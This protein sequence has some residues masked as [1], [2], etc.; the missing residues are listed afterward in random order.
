MR[1]NN[2][3]I[4]VDLGG[5]KLA[6]GV[7]DAHGR[8]L[9]KH[10]TFDHKDLSEEGVLD[11]MVRNICEALKIAGLSLSDATGAGILFPGHIR[12]PEGITL[13]TS[14]LPGF[15]NFPL[16]KKMEER[17]GIP[18]LADNDA[19]AQA[20]AEYLYGAGKGLN[21]MI[22]LTIS[23]GIGG[24]I[25]IDGKL[26]RGATGTA[27]EFGHMIIDRSGNYNCTCGNQ[28][29]FLATAAG[30]ALPKIARRI[31]D[32]LHKKGMCSDLPPGCEDFSSFDGRVMAEGCADDNKL[33]KAVME[34]ISTYVGIGLY[35]IFQIFNPEGVVIGGGL[36][37]LPD[38]FIE[39]I[40]EICYTMAGT[41]MYD[42]ME[43][44]K[45]L[46]GIDAAMIGAASLFQ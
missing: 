10:I 34:Q 46:L 21:P 8:I 17:L 35:N 7:I 29:C 39:K 19:N 20:L 43:I 15:R 38:D 27:G 18:C 32:E 5:T 22:F 42:K 41:M 36:A 2:I 37:N 6:A 26:Y 3:R 13:T 45:G 33:C 9:G 25:I 12:W 23:T 1:S 4:G 30:I 44:R 14:N 16:R 31:A 11:C 40:T 28:G 24:G